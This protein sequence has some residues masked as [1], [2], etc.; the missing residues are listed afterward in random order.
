MSTTDIKKCSF[1][2][3]LHSMAK[4][5][6]LELSTREDFRGDIILDILT[7]NEKGNYKMRSWE[8]QIQSIPDQPQTTPLNAN[9]FEVIERNGYIDG[10]QLFAAGA[11]PEDQI[12]L[13]YFCSF[14]FCANRCI[15]ITPW[16]EEAFKSVSE[17]YHLFYYEKDETS[18]FGTGLP[19][20]LRDR[21]LAMNAGERHLLGHA[22]WLTAPC[23][24][25][26]LAD[27]MPESKEHAPN[28]GPGSFLA[29]VSYGQNGNN[30][31]IKQYYMQ[32]NVNSLIGLLNFQR[33]QGDQETS[34]PSSLFGAPP[35]TDTTAKSDA[36][37]FENLLDFI[38]DLARNFDDMN[39]SVIRAIVR[40]NMKFN[41]DPMIKGDLETKAVGSAESLIRNAIRE[42]VSF[43]LQSMA[44]LPPSVMKHFDENRLAEILAK[45]MFDDINGLIRPAEE[46]AAELNQDAQKQAEIDALQTQ[47]AQIKGM[48]DQAKAEAQS[49][50]A[51]K[52]RAEIP[53]DVAKKEIDNVR[54]QVEIAD[55]LTGVQ[56]VG[57]A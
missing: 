37:R 22:A 49:A 26:N 56:N 54:G 7:T 57:T 16:P 28:F 45:S 55:A 38:K 30:N 46:V 4:H 12:D 48:Y 13:E 24:E 25:I 1:A 15:K 19:K 40:W 21:Q 11:I 35:V 8:T 2:Y 32:D 36:I 6:M 3:E 23:G 44:T 53:H 51:E 39:T 43:F 50:K 29:R 42:Q 41:P 33:S 34:L 17:L 52:I 27:L 10:K 31:I 9:A 18:I 14:W 20:I 47:L 5:E